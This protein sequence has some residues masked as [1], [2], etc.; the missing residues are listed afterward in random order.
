MFY[1]TY[2][3]RLDDKG[4]LI[5]PAKLRDGLK[6]LGDG[7]LMITQGQERCLYVFPLPVFQEMHA[8]LRAQAA[9]D[10][11]ARH[12]ERIMLAS[13]SQER[14][15]S[16]GRITVPPPLRAFAGLEKG[17]TVI[18][19]GTRFEIWATPIWDEYKAEQ[20]ALLAQQAHS[21]YM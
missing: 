1:G 10:P 15:D 18:G 14:P 3:P 17:L 20:E 8:R 19:S 13:A 9:M 6:A 4:R 2:T 7:D 11:A 16:Q 5:L 12:L 21:F